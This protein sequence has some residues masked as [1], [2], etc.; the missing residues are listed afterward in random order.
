MM[1]FA[2]LLSLPAGQPVESL[3]AILDAVRACPKV[4]LVKFAVE[5]EEARAA[6]TALM[7]A[8]Q[9]TPGPHGSVTGASAGEQ[10]VEKTSGEEDPRTGRQ[11]SNLRLSNGPR[12]FSV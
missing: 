11:E 1:T 2:L 9:F 3:G 12:K 10:K 6:L 8:P 5:T 7:P 4:R